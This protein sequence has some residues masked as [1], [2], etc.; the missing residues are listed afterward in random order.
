MEY[1]RLHLACG[2]KEKARQIL[3]KAKGMIEDMGYRRRDGEAAELEGE[4]EPLK[5]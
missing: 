3:A 5:H 2:E 1:T 4:L